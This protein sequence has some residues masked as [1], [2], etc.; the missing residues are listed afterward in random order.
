MHGISSKKAWFN[1]VRKNLKAL[2]LNLSHRTYFDRLDEILNLLL[3]PS[4]KKW[5]LS[6]T[7]SI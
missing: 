1:D 5:K 6:R 4:E 3:M 7:E 2:F